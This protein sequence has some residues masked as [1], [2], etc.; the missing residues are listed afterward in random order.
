M[1]FATQDTNIIFV[2]VS[3]LMIAPGE[4]EHGIFLVSVYFHSKAAPYTTRLLRHP[5]V[6][7]AEA[8]LIISVQF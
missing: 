8:K 7:L 5:L 1:L 2:I 3:F 4:S 6:S